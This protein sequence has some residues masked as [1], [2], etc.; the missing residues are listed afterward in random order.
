MRVDA[1]YLGVL[2]AQTRGT[3]ESCLYGARYCE[4]GNARLANARQAAKGECRH[5]ILHPPRRKTW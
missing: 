3:W 1:G 4:T 2:L 5:I